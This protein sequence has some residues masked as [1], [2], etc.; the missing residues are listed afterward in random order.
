AGQWLQGIANLLRTPMTRRPGNR[1][2]RFQN[3]CFTHH[4]LLPQQDPAEG[5]SQCSINRQIVCP[6]GV[7]SGISCQADNADTIRLRNNCNSA[8]SRSTS[9]SRWVNTSRTIGQGE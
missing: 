6:S 2:N 7:P 9:A 8:I 4:S 5:S 3:R 1:Q